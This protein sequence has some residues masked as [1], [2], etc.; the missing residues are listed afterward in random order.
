VGDEKVLKKR[1]RGYVIVDDH[2]LR[3]LI[4]GAPIPYLDRQCAVE[5]SEYQAAG[6]LWN[7]RELAVGSTNRRVPKTENG[8]PRVEQGGTPLLFC[9]DPRPLTAARYPFL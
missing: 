4:H 6:K 8:V 2:H 9:G 3:F 5:Q 7:R 1:A